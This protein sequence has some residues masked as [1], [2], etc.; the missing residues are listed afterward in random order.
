MPN[1]KSDGVP[2][3]STVNG[4][5]SPKL[6]ITSNVLSSGETGCE[7]IESTVA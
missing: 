2:S 3:I 5:Y 6:Y 1:T 4:M 7:S